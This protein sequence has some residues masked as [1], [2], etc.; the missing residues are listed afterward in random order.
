MELQVKSFL[1]GIK[2]EGVDTARAKPQ[3]QGRVPRRKAKAIIGEAE[4]SAPNSSPARKS[5]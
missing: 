1:R 4:K 5:G 2:S 3:Y